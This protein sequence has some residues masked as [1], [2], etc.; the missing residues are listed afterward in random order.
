MDEEFNGVN[1]Y[2]AIPAVVAHDATLA[3]AAR[4]IFGEIYSLANVYNTVFISNA[5]LAKR[6]N[7]GMSTVTRH[8]SALENAGYI[9]TTLYYKEGT[10]EVDRREIKVNLLSKMRGRSPQK[11]AYPPVKNEQEKNTY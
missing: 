5:A 4:L 1:Y 8:I 9:T 3:P 6:Y 2:L 7:L 11:W 10:A